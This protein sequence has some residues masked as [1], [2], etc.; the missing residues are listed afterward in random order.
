MNPLLLEALDRLLGD[1]ERIS[2]RHE[3]VTDTDVR[4][5]LHLTLNYYFVWGNTRERFPRSFGMFSAEGDR[6]VGK[7]VQKF[8]DA[9]GE[10]NELAAIPVG[11]ARLDFLQHAGVKTEGGMQWDEFFGHRESPLPPDP[12]PE[13]LFLEADYIE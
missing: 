5:A 4:E 12:L 2:T 3:E 8:L 1:L 7:A 6:L 10:S 13:F 9:I 11:K